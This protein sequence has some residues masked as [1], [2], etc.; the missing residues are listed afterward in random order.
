MGIQF[1]TSLGSS[2]FSKDEDSCFCGKYLLRF[3]DEEVAVRVVGGPS[4]GGIIRGILTK[5]NLKSGI[6][7]VESFENG[8]HHICCKSVSSIEQSPFPNGDANA[9]S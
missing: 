8:V 6:F 3:L 7:I 9:P 1:H 4:G 2:C 5:I